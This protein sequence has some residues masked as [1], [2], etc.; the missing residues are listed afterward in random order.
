[1]SNSRIHIVIVFC[2]LF[3]IKANAQLYNFQHL[4]VE[5][6]FPQ[7]NADD[8]IQ[9]YNG[10]MWIGTQVGIVKYDGQKYEIYNE[11]DGLANHIVSN[12]YESSDKNLWIGTRNGVSVKL[13]DTLISYSQKNGLTGKHVTHIWE[14]QYEKLWVMTQKGLCYFKNNQFHEVSLPVNGQI[15]K[16]HYFHNDSLYLCTNKGML[17]QT[18]EYSFERRYPEINELN[19]KEFV[20]QKD[21]LWLATSTNGLYKKTKTTIE[22]FANNSLLGTLATTTLLLDNSGRLWIGTEGNGFFLRKGNTFQQFTDKNGMHN[23]SVLK[24]MEDTE[25]NIWVG[26]RNGVIIFNPH[27]PFSHYREANQSSEESLFGIMQD[28]NGNYWFTTYGAGLSKYDGSKWSYYSK[29]DGLKDNRLFQIIEDENQNKWIATG[30]HGIVKFD[31]KNFTVYDANNGFLNERVFNIMFDKKGNLWGCTQNSGPFKYDGHSFTR[32]GN[33]KD[34]PT[35]VMS[36]ML[37]TAENI[38]FGTIGDGLLVYNGEKFYKPQIIG[39]IQP[40]YIRSLT[41]DSLGNIWAGTASKG[42]CKLISLGNNQYRFE[43]INTNQGLNSNNIYFLISTSN[44]ILWA[45]TEIGINKIKLNKNQE[46]EFIHSY[47]RS[48]GFIGA[49]TSINGAMEDNNGDIWFSSL[50]GATRYENGVE[51]RNTIEAQ[52]HITGL[53]LFY[54]KVD[55][56]K[57][58]KS[59]NKHQLPINLKLPYQKNHLTFN[60][61][62]LSYTNPNKVFYKY[63]L[64]GLDQDWSPVT[65]NTEAVYANVPP[66]QYTFKVK[67][68]NNDG[69]WNKAPTIY[70]FE[71]LTPFWQNT[72]FYIITGFIIIAIII[73]YINFRIK[74]LRKAKINLEKKV[75]E[76]TSEIELQKQEIQDKNEELNQRTEEIASQRDELNEQNHKI[77]KLYEEQTQ[78]IKYAKHIQKAVLSSI[79]PLKKHFKDYFIL[80]HPH[81]IVSGDFYY[82][83]EVREWI[84]VAAVDSTG[85]GV[86]GGF[87]SML[88]ISFL[89]EIIYPMEEIQSDVIL[90]KLRKYV[91]NSLKQK[92]R[93]G[94]QKEGMEMSLTAINTKTCICQFSG[95]Q[96][97]VLLIRNND[98]PKLD[99]DIVYKNEQ[100]TMY[101]L[102]PDKMPISVF[103]QM[104]I[105]TKNTFKLYKGDK[106][107]YFTDGYPD[108][109][110]G[111][112][113]KKLSKKIFFELLFKH[114]DLSC[115]EQKDE[116]DSFYEK[117]RGTFDKI[118]DVLVMGIEI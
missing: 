91:I 2:F 101:Y 16:N 65:K 14:D 72:W 42:V 52:T 92:G 56:R 95:A 85:H 81:S 87:M 1:M 38:W 55:W 99:Y 97:P 59:Q 84:I 114:S 9:D 83:A 34:I 104:E 103:P 54:Q 69:V 15:I 11:K 33:D 18:G 37:D 88:G 77:E 45:G 49:E 50:I 109:F 76:R 61:I 70:R 57:Q 13:G 48:E 66:G 46:L 22:N 118:D 100:K 116:L 5:N 24:L 111:P 23:T 27:N 35:A 68:C 74:N 86:P 105:F 80:F 73:F 17:I 12:I 19:I 51:R 89:N 44:N 107:Y 106:L 98:N 29:E 115:K 62:G 60:Y 20:F 90:N 30:G 8:I 41:L 78:S 39:N 21:T 53:K 26:G 58:S 40:P 4:S 113:G 96:N 75:L 36:C 43:S 71:V 93:P 79:E 6:G 110:G 108:Q 47:G 25:G 94:E 67:S 102:P 64:E 28:K 63:K 31:G 32:Y 3:I 7:A 82:V 10:F 112:K 117:W